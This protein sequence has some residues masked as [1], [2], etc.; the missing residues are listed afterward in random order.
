M[1]NNYKAGIPTEELTLTNGETVVFYKF[2]TTGESRELQRMLLAGG[3]FSTEKGKLEDIPS[4]IILDIQDK[5]AEFL[6][7]EVKHKDGTVE[8]YNK[9]WL[10]RLP[11]EDGN[12]VY[13]KINKINSES[14]LTPKEKKD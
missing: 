5:S 7:K 12:K 11:L 9:D 6:V 10:Y 8:A 13:D 3:K 14:N 2:L 4:S 1:T